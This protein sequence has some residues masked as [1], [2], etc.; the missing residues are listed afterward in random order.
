M[1]RLY[2]LKRNI[3]DIFIS[4]FVL[5]GRLISHIK[6]LEKEYKIFYFFPF[7]HIGGAEK[8]HLQIAQSTGGKDAIIFFT[9]H[10]QNEG[11]L[12]E[13]IATQCTIRDIS[14]YTDNKWF[15]FL[16]LIFRGIISGYVNNQRIKASIFNGQCN[17]GYKISPWITKRC[18]Q[19]ELIHSLNSF[20]YIRIPFLPFI[21]T[22]VM[23]SKRRIGDHLDLYRK[24]KIP[25]KYD[26]KIQF[27]SNA[28]DLP[29]SSISKPMGPFTILFVGRGTSEKRPHI[30]TLIAEKMHATQS[31]SFQMVG[32]VTESIDTAIYPYIKFWA[33]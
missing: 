8:V 11:Y 27:I 20:S 12:K 23:I 29:K 4:P 1:Y 26:T 5:L 30:F 24:F 19:V 31:I 33:M 16:N 32:D 22:T 14:T 28:I 17:F 21:D 7:Y 6:P 13:F 3:E 25:K 15:Y 2:I 9:R 10:S 18:R